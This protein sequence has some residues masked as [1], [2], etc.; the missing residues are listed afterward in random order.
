M[1]S[2]KKRMSGANSKRSNLPN[3]PSKSDCHQGNAKAQIGALSH[4]QGSAKDSQATFRKEQKSRGQSSSIRDSTHSAGFDAARITQW[5]EN[6]ATGFD[7]PDFR[8]Y[9]QICSTFP[10]D[11]SLTALASALPGT[12]FTSDP[13][14]SSL[15]PHFFQPYGQDMESFPSSTASPEAHFA[16][17]DISHDLPPS[18]AFDCSVNYQDDQFAFGLSSQGNLPFEA[19]PNANDLSYDSMR[20]RPAMAMSSP[21]DF[22]LP[23]EWDYELVTA[24]SGAN[25]MRVAPSVDWSSPTALTPSTSSLQSE[26][27]DPQLETSI[28]ATMQDFNWATAQAVPMVNEMEMLPPSGFEES[29]HVHFDNSYMDSERSV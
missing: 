10:D 7:T 4:G 25:T 6:S 26:Y 17:M 2:H 22:T 5:A 24:F 1:A 16:R 21:N 9:S 14:A 20:M 23:S 19:L 12:F 29:V 15:Q 8:G 18:Q 11:P 13:N 28:S 27:M 3:G